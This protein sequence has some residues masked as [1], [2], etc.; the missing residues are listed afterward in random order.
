MRTIGRIP[1]CVIT[2]LA[3]SCAALTVGLALAS[4]TAALELGPR[5]E[6]VAGDRPLDVAIANS[7]RNGGGTLT[8]HRNTSTPGTISLAPLVDYSVNTEAGG[9]GSGR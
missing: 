4:A 9:G 2:R 7:G 1:R 3:P 8:V 5:I 6:V